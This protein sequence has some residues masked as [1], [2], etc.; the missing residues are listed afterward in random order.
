VV[1]QLSFY[2]PPQGSKIALLYTIYESPKGPTKIGITQNDRARG[3]SLQTGNPRPLNFGIGL[4]CLFSQDVE[5]R[6][7]QRL[8]SK[9]LVGEW[10][11]VTPEEA[12]AAIDAVIA[13]GCGPGWRDS[14]KNATRFLTVKDE[15]EA[16]WRAAA[17]QNA[18]PTRRLG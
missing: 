1:E 13:E 3:Q 15:C 12:E 8:A 16:S 17:L 11:D 18:H 7:H 10:F 5:R 14:R 4:P 9:R 2:W 6:V